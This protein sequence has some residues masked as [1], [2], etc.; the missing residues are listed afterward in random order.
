MAPAWFT[1]AMGY[2]GLKEVPGKENNPVIVGWWA[3]IRAPF[4]DD[5]TPW[6]AGF[7]GG[8]LEECGLPST[9]SASARSYMNYGVSLQCA[10]VGAIVVFQRGTPASG[11]GHVGFVAGQDAKG[12][13]M[14][15]GGNQ[16]DCVSIKPFDRTRILGYRWPKEVPLPAIADKYLPLLNS[17]GKLSTNEA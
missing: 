15:L 12:N 10:Y 13:L 6:C 8:V 5:E 7:V 1:R 2:L 11:L 17:D 14:V 3:K 9:R 4:K 16:G